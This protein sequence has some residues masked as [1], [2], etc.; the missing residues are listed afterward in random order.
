MPGD[1]S[2]GRR[3]RIVEIRYYSPLQDDELVA[4]V[5]STWALVRLVRMDD[6]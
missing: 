2:A 6:L 1:A 3:Y 5:P 4:G